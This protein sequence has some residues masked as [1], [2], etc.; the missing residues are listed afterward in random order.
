MEGFGASVID[1]RRSDCASIKT[2]CSPYVDGGCS[3][4]VS[5]RDLMLSYVHEGCD[6]FP[7]RIINVVISYVVERC[8]KKKS[9]CKELYR[10]SVKGWM[11]CCIDGGGDGAYGNEKKR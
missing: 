3:N 9:R 8:E 2:C 11:L 6:I 1:G 5:M 10:M 7:S 4:F